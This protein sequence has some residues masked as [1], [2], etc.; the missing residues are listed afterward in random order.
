MQVVAVACSMQ[1]SL[2]TVTIN[3]HSKGRMRKSV[4]MVFSRQIIVY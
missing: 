1:Q 4:K 3:I 2:N